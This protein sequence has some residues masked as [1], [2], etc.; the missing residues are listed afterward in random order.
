MVMENEAEDLFRKIFIILLYIANIMQSFKDNTAL[1]KRVEKTE[2]VRLATSVESG[3]WPVLLPTQY[4][5][6]HICR[7]VMAWRRPAASRLLKS[8]NG[9][10]RLCESFPTFDEL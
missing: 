8:G 1:E 3:F 5:R 7:N 4:M 2:K 10:F 9:F 6:P